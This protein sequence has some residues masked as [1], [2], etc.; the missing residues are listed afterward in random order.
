MQNYVDELLSVSGTNASTAARLAGLQPSTIT[1]AKNPTLSTLLKLSDGLRMNM[2]VGF[3]PIQDPSAILDFESIYTDQPPVGDWLQ[4]AKRA[5][6]K[7]T[8]AN[9]AILVAK[10][11]QLQN[12][13]GAVLVDS[14]SKWYEIANWADA[15]TNNLGWW[16]SGPAACWAAGLENA[17]KTTE[18]VVYSDR[19]EQ[20]ASA[21]RNAANGGKTWVLPSSPQ[22]NATGKVLA[23]GQQWVNIGRATIDAL[24]TDWGQQNTDLIASWIGV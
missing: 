1:R 12:R 16:M 3:E 4:Y 17:D 22:I 15:A 10:H 11:S 23:P 18:F 20:V 5:T 2:N 13:D 21:L 9:L 24:C 19:P 6:P 14:P 8:T 7:A